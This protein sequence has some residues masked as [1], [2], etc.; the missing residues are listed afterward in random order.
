LSVKP[1][2]ERSDAYEKIYAV[3][4]RIPRG[5]VASYGQ[6]AEFAGLGG[7]AR[8]VGYALHAIPDEI[9][10]PWQRV[11]NAKGEISPRSD[12]LMEGVQQSLLAA[13]GVSIDR[14]GRIDLARFRWQPRLR[15]FLAKP[16]DRKGK[17]TSKRTKGSK[18]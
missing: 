6:V 14:N 5:K 15:S 12:P 11:V 16:R 4:R 7:H 10:I 8:Q 9:E 2:R 18:R 13:E 17:S 1:K 3:V